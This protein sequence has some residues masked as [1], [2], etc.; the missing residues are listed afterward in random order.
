MHGAVGAFE[1]VRARQAG[2]RDA[3]ATYS[4]P[5]SV[6][7]STNAAISSTD[8]VSLS[9]T[10]YDEL[11]RVYQTETFSIASDGTIEQENSEDKKLA[12]RIFYNRNNQPV[13]IDRVGQIADDDSGSKGRIFTQYDFN[14]LG[15][16]VRRDHLDTGSGSD[17]GWSASGGTLACT[18]TVTVSSRSTTTTPTTTRRSA[19]TSTPPRSR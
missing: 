8:R 5:N 6:S 18:G 7:E 12:T 1:Q 10:H 3:V 14:G 11:G 2:L 17:G 9:K 19:S 16:L 4:D 15:R 13:A